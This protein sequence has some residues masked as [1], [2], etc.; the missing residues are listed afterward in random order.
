[1]FGRQ[2]PRSIWA[3][4]TYPRF[5]AMTPGGRGHSDLLVCAGSRREE[6]DTD[7]YEWTEDEVEEMVEETDT[8]MVEETDAEAGSAALNGDVEAMEEDDFIPGD[9][10]N[11]DS[12]YDDADDADVEDTYIDHGVDD[13]IM[14]D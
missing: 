1:M 8:E 7:E 13:E 12:D 2:N 5:P 10:Y 3:P 6:I 9:Y 4:Q 11:G 14:D